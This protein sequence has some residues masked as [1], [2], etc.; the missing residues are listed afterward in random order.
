MSRL[1]LAEAA[2]LL[3]DYRESFTSLEGDDFS[4]FGTVETYI[5]PRS[6][7]NLWGLRSRVKTRYLPI[8]YKNDG[9]PA[10]RFRR[11]GQ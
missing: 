6:W 2:I 11:P 5:A 10:V 3:D 4:I 9:G 8:P 7:R 1:T